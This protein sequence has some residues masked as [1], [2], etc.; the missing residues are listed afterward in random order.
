MCYVYG[1]TFYTLFNLKL[2]SVKEIF[3]LPKWHLVF[4]GIFVIPLYFLHLIHLLYKK[5]I[6]V[7]PFLKYLLFPVAILIRGI[8]YIGDSIIRI[9]K[10]S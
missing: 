4:L 3:E 10:Q 1:T 5:C 7:I 9:G 2:K 6:N 8:K